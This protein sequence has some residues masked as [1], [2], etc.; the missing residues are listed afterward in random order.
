MINDYLDGIQKRYP[1]TREVRE[2]VDE[3]RD[4]LHL[5]TEDLQSQGR[6]YEEAAREAVAALGDITPLLEQVSGNVRT[7]TINRLNRNNALLCTA[8]ML[9]EYLLGW[10]G[11][12]LQAY[13]YGIN[14]LA[15]FGI[16]T[17]MAILCLGIW[18]VITQIKYRRQRDKAD[19]VSMPFRQ[20]MRT[21]LLGWLGITLIL[22]I[23][24]LSSGPDS[25]V[26]FIWPMIGVAN[27][28]LNIFLYHRQLKSGRYDATV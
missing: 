7:V 21:A 1:N 5:K 10:L 9:A 17:G 19:I 24:N 18:P 3:L 15:P 4:T 23:C 13:E 16:F 6:T 8:F 12:L 14:Y 11:F 2:Q 27:W 22:V 20:M 28:P 26:W 25:G